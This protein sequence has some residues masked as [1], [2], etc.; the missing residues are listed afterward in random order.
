M[1]AAERGELGK[2][3]RL[4]ASVARQDAEQRG[5]WLL[6]DAEA[7]LARQFDREDALW[8]EAVQAAQEEVAHANAVIDQRCAEMGVPETFRPTLHSYFFPRGENASASRRA[9]LRK[10]VRSQVEARVKEAKVE[11]NREA[12][13][14][15]TQLAI[16]ALTSDDAR[17]Y[18]EAMPGADELLPPIGTLQLTSG[19]LVALPEDVTPEAE[20]NAPVTAERNG[21]PERNG[22]AICGKEIARGGGLYCK[23]AH[24]QKAYRERQRQRRSSS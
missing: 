22:C 8:K 11:I 23:P 6:A 15:L 21:A 12:E 4:R 2:L 17:A 14:Q 10:V 7:K 5:A 18:L 16:G 13:R 19:E 9:E 3:V 20:R 1:T 24:R